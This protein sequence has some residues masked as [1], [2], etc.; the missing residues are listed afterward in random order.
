MRIETIRTLDGAN[1]HHQASVLVM[2]L[3][4]EEL[5]RKETHEV[6]GFMDQLLTLLPGI[7]QHHC[8]N[9][10]AD[11]VVEPTPTTIG[12]DHIT[13]RVALELATLA[14]IPVH[15]A[16]VLYVGGPQRCQ[17]VIEFTDEAGMR[18]LLHT[19]VEL[20]EALIKGETPPLEEKLDE[21]RAL[22][23]RAVSEPKTY[24]IVLAARG[25]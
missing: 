19:A 6:T 8:A 1:I 18:C 9:G 24:A 4:L 20:V 14:G 3:D 5:A 23:E 2:T 15:H 10:R 16:S 11:G 12:F 13:A 21:A 22:I 25:Y 17:I 7:I